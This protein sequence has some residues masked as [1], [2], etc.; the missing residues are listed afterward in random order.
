MDFH[1]TFRKF[2]VYFIVNIIADSFFGLIV[3]KMIWEKANI[4]SGN[5][6]EIVS[7]LIFIAFSLIIYAYQ[8]WYEGKE[9]RSTEP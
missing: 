8:M 7:V 6:P 9:K 3:L 1:F 2:G 5:M 4:Y